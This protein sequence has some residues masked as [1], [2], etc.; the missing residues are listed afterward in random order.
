MKVEDSPS[1]NHTIESSSCRHAESQIR[2]LTQKVHRNIAFLSTIQANKD[3]ISL[4]KYISILKSEPS[5]RSIE[6]ISILKYYLTHSNLTDKFKKDAIDPM[7]Y[8]KMIIISSTY[9]GYIHINKG[10]TL[11]D[12]SSKGNYTYI[13]AEGEINLY[14]PKENIQKL[15][16]YEYFKALYEMYRRGEY[17]LI[18]MT[19][20]I[21][22]PVYKVRYEDIPKI[23]DIVLKIQFSQNEKKYEID[24]EFFT[25]CCLTSE[26][27]GIN[28][29][30]M[31]K[32][33]IKDRINNYLKSISNEICGLYLYM[34]NETETNDVSIFTYE[35][36]NQVSNNEYL[37]DIDH[38]TYIHKAIAEEDTEL[39]VLNN[40]I[41]SQ[42]VSQENKK[43][44]LKELSFIFDNFFFTSIV[45][46]KFDREY[47]PFFIREI[48]KKG[49]LLFTENDQVNYIYFIQ[50]GDIELLSTKS[51][52]E[53]HAMIHILNN[54]S[55]NEDNKHYINSQLSRMQNQPVTMLNQLNNKQMKKMMILGVKET[56]GIESV[57]Y[58]LNFLFTGRVFSKTAT[59][60]KI[61]VPHLLFILNH[62]EKEAY[63]DF[64]ESCRRKLNIIETRL[65]N[66][67]KSELE[68]IDRKIDLPETKEHKLFGDVLKEHKLNCAIYLNEN[69]I[70]KNYEKA[71]KKR[72]L[73][74]D[75]MKT[76]VSTNIN[77]TKTTVRN[78]TYT[79]PLPEIRNSYR[80][81][82]ITSGKSRQNSQ[83]SY[84]D[85]MFHMVQKELQASMKT[86]I[87][88]PQSDSEA[89]ESIV[90][91]ENAF[92][93]SLQSTENES[94]IKVNTKQKKKKEPYKAPIVLE[95]LNR[96]SIFDEDKNNK[97]PFIPY[98]VSTPM[99]EVGHLFREMHE[100]KKRKNMLQ[101]IKKIHNI[102]YKKKIDN[103]L[104]EM[105][106]T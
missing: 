34:L 82:N 17:P 54:I 94:R 92:L 2:Q 83:K 96:F 13:I 91:S 101:S 102:S 28:F 35:L 47:F 46:R 42:Y 55:N 36:V 25:H 56:I 4:S 80:S 40:Y 24:E 1:K 22:Q 3:Q 44:K 98:S 100:I 97:K 20:G 86:L 32:I 33:G 93:T 105:F 78:S 48:H 58:G 75:I 88:S 66:V 73:S 85:R 74:L 63:D 95:K 50:E 81:Q 84:E 87:S 52:L 70:R 64:K 49:E 99:T 37:G 12:Y 79:T 68:K 29:D 14:S 9:V 60:Y 76:N 11:Y 7:N 53:I 103:K 65:A 104:N 90:N 72:E 5:S 15:S 89:K 106:Y 41:Y 31:G 23:R 21:N 51:I 43:I 30:T 38:E 18:K 39:C 26:E 57:L 77:T 45:K 16:G 8:E 6:D 69:K 67:N 62:E 27:L 59:L 19:I 71:S 10:E 61:S